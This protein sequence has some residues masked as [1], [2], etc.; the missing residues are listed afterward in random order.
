MRKRWVKLPLALLEIHGF[1]RHLRE[2]ALP[3]FSQLGSV[4]VLVPAITFVEVPKPFRHSLSDCLV[5]IQEEFLE[6]LDCPGFPEAHPFD[7]FDRCSP[8]TGFNRCVGGGFE[9]YSRLERPGDPA[10]EVEYLQGA[11]KLIE[12]SPISLAVGHPALLPMYNGDGLWVSFVV[13]YGLPVTIYFLI[14]NVLASYRGV[15]SRRSDLLFSGSIIIVMLLYFVTN[16]ILDY[17]PVA[18]IYLLA[19]SYLT[20]KG[21]HRRDRSAH[22]GLK[23]A[24]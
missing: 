5:L 2:Y 7:G 8:E 17:W 16:R 4:R 6:R 1:G 24:A 11:L 10:P 21:I 22:D 13:T 3:D 18:L 9:R 14:V 23:Y 15:T 12:D 20:T 19:F